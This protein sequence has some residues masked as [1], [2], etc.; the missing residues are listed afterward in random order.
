MFYICRNYPNLNRL[1]W[2]PKPNIAIIF[3]NK[4]Q[5]CSDLRLIRRPIWSI[6]YEC[7]GFISQLTS[8]IYIVSHAP[9]WHFVYAKLSRFHLQY[10]HVK[11]LS[12]S[13]RR[14]RHNLKITI[15]VKS[16]DLVHACSPK[17]PHNYRKIDIL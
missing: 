7:H 12:V 3:R 14:P 9:K 5:N 4:P 13:A 10:R 1:F 16:R 8:Y 15:F 17:A 2:R 11:L 6:M